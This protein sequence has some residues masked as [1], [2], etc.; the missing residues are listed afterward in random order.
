MAIYPFSG[1]KRLELTGGVQSISYDREATTS[2]Y[3]GVT[4]RLLNKTILKSA[5][6][7]DAMLFESAAAL[8]YDTSVFGPTGPILGERYRFA[9]APTFG[10]VTFATVTADYRRYVMPV[11][12]FTIA[13]RVMHLGRYGGASNDPR[14][15]PLLWTLRDV[16]RGYGDIGPGSPS[17]SNVTASRMLVGNIE[18]RFPFAALLRRSVS[19]GAL[20]IEGL[21]FSDT[22][23]FWT[24]QDARTAHLRCCGASAQASV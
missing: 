8:V 4:G 23:R 1:V 12:P 6:A 9:V 22:A 14:L 16:V 17:A 5:A 3:S 19:P 18:L 10:N 21:V 11:R 24:L 13:V 20:P 15:L 7:P 2:V